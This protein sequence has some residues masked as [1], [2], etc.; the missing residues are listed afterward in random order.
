MVEDTV[1]RMTFVRPIGA[2]V[3]SLL[4]HQLLSQVDFMALI[5]NGP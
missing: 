1:F 2:L 4:L 3:K 5:Q